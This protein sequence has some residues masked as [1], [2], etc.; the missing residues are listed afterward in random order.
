MAF[1]LKKPLKYKE[2]PLLK[3]KLKKGRRNV[4]QSD[5]DENENDLQGSEDE[6][7]LLELE[8]ELEEELAHVGVRD[9]SKGK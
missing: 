6:A 9:I 3:K 4:I 5:D 2:E 8:G 7:K 1:C